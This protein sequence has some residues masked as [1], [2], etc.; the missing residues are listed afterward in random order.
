MLFGVLPSLKA[1]DFQNYLVTLTLQVRKLP[2]KFAHI[3]PL[4][5]YIIVV[6][7]E[8]YKTCVCVHIFFSFEIFH[9]SDGMSK[10]AAHPHSS[11]WGKFHRLMLIVSQ[12]TVRKTI[13]MLHNY[14]SVFPGSFVWLWYL[15]MLSGPKVGSIE[16][17]ERDFP[18]MIINR[19]RVEKR[20]LINQSTHCEVTH[21]QFSI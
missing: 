11:V 4:S 2:G 14:K 9:L 17:I 10:K 16:K 18:S 19:V 1:Y 8:I 20:N 6:L 3:T 15:P 7:S 21:G 12:L 5:M 13:V